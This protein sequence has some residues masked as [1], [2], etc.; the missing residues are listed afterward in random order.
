MPETIRLA[1][2]TNPHPKEQYLK[3]ARILSRRGGMS[4]SSHTIALRLPYD[5]FSPIHRNDGPREPGYIRVGQCGQHFRHILGRRQAACRVALTRLD[6]V[7]FVAGDRTHG[8]RVG[9]A[10]P[11]AVNGDTPWGQFDR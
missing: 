2:R 11:Q 3:C 1:A 9:H 7:G 6:E 8:G 5:A 4:N 10:G